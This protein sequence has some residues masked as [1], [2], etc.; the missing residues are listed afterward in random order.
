M[1]KERDT[2]LLY[3]CLTTTVAVM[4]LSPSGTQSSNNQNQA[5]CNCCCRADASQSCACQHRRQ[6]SVMSSAQPAVTPPHPPH[7]PPHMVR[8]QVM[9]GQ[10]HPHQPPKNVCKSTHAVMF[11]AH[12]HPM[13]L[14]PPACLESCSRQPAP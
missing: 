7:P 8:R 10:P 13:Q 4:T 9:R 5:K 1:P 14:P 2:L 12:F 6:C 3:A 11:A